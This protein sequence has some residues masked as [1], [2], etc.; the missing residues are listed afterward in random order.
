MQFILGGPGTGKTTQCLQEINQMIESTNTAPLYYLVPE[1]FSMQ[2]EK[3]LLTNRSAATKVQ[4]LSFNRMAYR[5]F[6]V[7]GKPPGKLADDLGKQMLLRKVLLETTDD[8]TY[9][10]SAADKHGFV[11]TLAHTITELNQYRISTGDLRLFA[12]NAPPILKAKLTDT[13]LLLEKYRETVTDRYLLTDDMLEILC[14]KLEENTEPNPLLDGSYFWVDGFSGFTPQERY[15]LCL[16]AK[17]AKNL[18]ITLTTRDRKNYT[19]PLSAPTRDTIEKLTKNAKNKN[20][21]IKPHIYREENKRHSPTSELAF[22]VNN[23][24]LINPKPLDEKADKNIR[25]IS[26]GDRYASVY[27]AAAYILYFVNEK[28]YSFKDI[29]ILCGDRSFY[30]KILT[31]TFDRLNIPL[32]V[33][34]E[35]DILSHPLTELIRSALETV[36]RNC[37][38]E[39]VVRFFK[40]QLTGLDGHTLDVLENYALAFGIKSYRW[41]YPF[42]NPIAEKGR[43]Q[44]LQ[45]LNVF[46]KINPNTKATIKDHSQRVFDMLYQ[47]KVPETLQK[48]Y[49]NEMEAGNTATAQFHKQIWPKCCEIFDKLVEILG[50]EKVTLKTFAAI[51]DA[52]LA[53]ANLGRIPPTSNQVILGDMGRSRY[54]EIKAMI[55]LGANEN[56]LPPTP[57]PSGLFTDRERQTLRNASLEL[58]PEN[59]HSV[60]EGY[61]SLYT[62]LCQPKEKLIFIYAEAEPGGNKPLRPS[63]II[64][65]LQEMFPH[66]LPKHPP[67]F[68]EYGKVYEPQKTYQ[69][70]TTAGLYDKVLMIN[71]SRL[72]SFARCPF[73]YYVHHILNARERKR[74]QVLP[75]DL[76][77]L[78][79]DILAEFSKQ[80]WEKGI[81]ISKDEVAAIVNDL[82]STLTLDDNLYHGTS[83][84][85]HILSKVARASIHS[86]NAL[87]EHIK[88]GQFV[89]TLTEVDISNGAGINLD[90]GHRLILTGRV[91]RVD[92]FKTADGTEYLKIIDYKSGASKFNIDEVRAG[93]QMQLMLYMNILT[94]QRNAKPGGVF[95]FTIKDP[96]LDTDTFLENPVREGL[97]LKQFK[98]SGLAVSEDAPLNAMDI[99]LKAGME[100]SIIPVGVNKDGRFKKSAHP[101]DLADI[102]QLAKDVENKIKELGNAIINGEI[103]AKPHSKGP[104]NSCNFCKFESICK[105]SD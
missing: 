76:G 20:I 5:L 36:L 82:V 42:K 9:Y 21:S 19:D 93:I 48:W 59:I 95:Y 96:L 28:G 16:I 51:L 17:R 26:A 62:A 18:T 101:I 13:A 34:T 67:T 99:N 54:P 71:A 38:Y 37:S 25:I 81:E 91:D 47:L 60:N 86:I 31:T 22:F 77:N 100:S 65:K 41:K 7:L 104:K 44:L 94:K 105:R 45:A 55:V 83:R 53:N 74:F 8:L 6:A 69:S 27:S 35:T 4:V 57:T 61:Y 52:G 103:S 89:P 63:L 1:Q 87:T 92:T 84:N 3:L 24:S 73:A 78:Y 43:L 33:D 64:K 23:F 88:Q 29:A 10:K 80:T 90:T 14:K 72:E 40:T 70:F 50:D 75:A 85:K 2:S 97:L 12:E 79:H 32:F 39:S 15:V 58:G 11:E 102:N 46:D 30:E 56:V 98:M 66:L 68:I 49:D